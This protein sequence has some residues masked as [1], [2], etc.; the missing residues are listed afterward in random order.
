MPELAEPLTVVLLRSCGHTL[1]SIKLVSFFRCNRF[2]ASFF[3]CSRFSASAIMPEFAASVPWFP[4]VAPHV[5]CMV[6]KLKSMPYVLPEALSMI[7][8]VKLRGSH[9]NVTIWPD[10]VLLL[11]TRHGT[12]I[13]PSNDAEGVFQ[14]L[15]WRRL[16]LWELGLAYLRHYRQD[17]PDVGMDP[18][19]PITL[20]GILTP[21]FFLPKDKK[22]GER[23]SRHKPFVV[24]SAHVNGNWQDMEGCED[25]CDYSAFLFHI[26]QSGCWFGTLHL[27]D[28]GNKKLLTWTKFLLQRVSDHVAYRCPYLKYVGAWGRCDG[29]IWRLRHFERCQQHEWFFQRGCAMPLNIERPLETRD[30]SEKL[31]AR[32][33]WWSK[34]R[35]QHAATVAEPVESWCTEL[36]CLRACVT[37]ARQMRRSPD[38]TAVLHRMAGLLFKDF[39]EQAPPRLRRRVDGGAMRAAI[40]KLVWQRYQGQEWVMRCFGSMGSNVPGFIF[41]A[42][43]RDSY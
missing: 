7:G 36:R 12:I 24:V 43:A 11:H 10:G 6:A 9:V 42:E 4:V 16:A 30:C 40:A 33:D 22:E 23:V 19:A 37:L 13:D 15:E 27:R 28:I 41:P 21:G 32:H 38:E 2:F 14:S 34:A 25:L 18:S 8:A 31:D 26:F 20:A 1:F 3:C 35:A 29:I 39:W 5:D 17:H